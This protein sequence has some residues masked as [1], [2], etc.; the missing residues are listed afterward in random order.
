VASVHL[1]AESVEGYVQVGQEYTALR[2]TA[3]LEEAREIA[4]PAHPHR[5][6]P[7]SRGAFADRA[8]A[9]GR[10]GVWAKAGIASETPARCQLHSAHTF[11]GQR[12]SGSMNA[13]PS[14]F[15]EIASALQI[16][17]TPD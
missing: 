2:F 12:L 13:S 16:R 4:L 6:L 5:G 8:L 9:S 17:R 15:V 3:W 7:L 1:A 11:L 14:N 10:S